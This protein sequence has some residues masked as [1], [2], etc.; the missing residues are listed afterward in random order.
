MKTITKKQADR[1]FYQL[2]VEK[3]TYAE[4]QQEYNMEKTTLCRKMKQY[5]KEYGIKESETYGIKTYLRYKFYL[6]IFLKY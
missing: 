5:K 6:F 1:I 3:K 4:L 2:A